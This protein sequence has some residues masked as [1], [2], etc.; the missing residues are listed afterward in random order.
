M[1]LSAT[2]LLG[3]IGF[4]AM[5]IVAA[6]QQAS[7]GAPFPDPRQLRELIETMLKKAQVIEATPMVAANA[8]VKVELSN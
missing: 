8:E 1:R 4:D 5:R 6:V 3:A 2:D 7:A